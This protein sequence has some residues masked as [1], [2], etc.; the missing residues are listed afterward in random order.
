MLLARGPT[1]RPVVVTV[2][3]LTTVVA[4][5]YLVALS[6]IPEAL[7]SFG[8]V[9]PNNIGGGAALIVVCTVL[10]LKMQVR[11]VS[12]TNSGGVRQ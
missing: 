2:E 4:A 12:L 11:D 5:A 10:D 9:L 8:V 3:S 7:A 1:T 6:A